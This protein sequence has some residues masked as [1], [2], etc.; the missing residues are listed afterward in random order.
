MRFTP[1]QSRYFSNAPLIHVHKFYSYTH[2]TPIPILLLYVL[3][4]HALAGRAE[5]QEM[6]DASEAAD[7]GRNRRL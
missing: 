3:L 6:C 7:T 4:I 2:T 5:H 1:N